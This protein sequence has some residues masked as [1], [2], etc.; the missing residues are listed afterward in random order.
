MST[1][2]VRNLDPEWGE[3]FDLPVAF[4]EDWR[5]QRLRDKPSAW[6]VGNHHYPF[7]VEMIFQMVV[8]WQL[9]GVVVSAQVPQHLV[10]E[11]GDVLVL[12]S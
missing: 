5:F 11:I 12:Q 3:V 1:V 8:G 6:E 4:D 2:K 7:E 9:G 10:S